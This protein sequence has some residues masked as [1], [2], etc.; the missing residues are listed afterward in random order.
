MVAM[1]AVLFQISM[2]R[3]R[4]RHDTGYRKLRARRYLHH[5]GDNRCQRAPG[6][7]GGRPQANAKRAGVDRGVSARVR[8]RL[9]RGAA[10]RGR[11][12][13]RRREP[14][15]RGMS[16]RGVERCGVRSHSTR[17]GVTVTLRGAMP[18]G[19]RTLR[20]RYDLTFASYALTMKSAGAR[21]ATTTT[22]L[23]GSELSA[24]MPLARETAPTSRLD[25][26]RG[27]FALG[28]THILPKGARPHPLRGGHLSLE[29]ARA[30]D[31]VASQR[32][33]ARAL[34]DARPHALRRDRATRL[35]RRADDRPVDCLCRGREPCDVG[36]Q[37]VARGAGVRVRLA[38]RHGVRRACCA[39]SRCRV[40][41]S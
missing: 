26:A 16:C 4:N 41:R 17:L 13:R 11:A 24:P 20:W 3:A 9:R 29:P 23:E 28:F 25:V 40:P 1:T 8:R 7:A 14:P 21:D 5:R 27:Y 12:V 30:S 36:A 37:A 19:T 32:F 10:S 22:W 31:P 38:A 35:D 39:S 34:A 18:R 6:A 2:R 15:A 33:H